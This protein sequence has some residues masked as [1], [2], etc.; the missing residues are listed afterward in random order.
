MNTKQTVPCWICGDP[1]NTREHKLKKSDLK[2]IFG[3]PSQSEPI[4]Y[5]SDKK[6]NIRIGGL[7]N[8]YLKFPS[9]ICAHCNNT[10]SQSHDRA[11]EFLSSELRSRILVLGDG[12]VVRANRIFKYDTRRQM[13]NVHLYFVKLFGCQIIEG[14][15][16]IKIEGFSA[17]IMNETAHP[18]VFLKF[19]FLEQTEV[20]RMTAITDVW[21]TQTSD[22]LCAFASWSYVVDNLVVH[23]MFAAEGEMRQGLRNAWHPSLGTSKLILSDFCER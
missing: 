5:H 14:P 6:R 4:F 20:T 18:R 17:A 9:L 21:T 22:G 2:A 8:K 7:D 13:L 1:A 10:R 3:A 16:P 23:V 15:I 19:G 12:D 11:W